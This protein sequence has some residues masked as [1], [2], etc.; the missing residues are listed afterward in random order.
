LR[1]LNRISIFSL[2]LIISGLILCSA[3]NEKVENERS[4]ISMPVNSVSSTSSAIV[5]TLKFKNYQCIDT[6]G[7]GIEAFHLLVPIDW[8]SEG[9]VNWVMDN[10]GMPA[11]SYLRVWKPGQKE[12]FNIYPNQSLFW[13]TNP[14]VAAM[15]PVGSKYFGMEVLEPMKSDQALKKIVIPRFRPA[16]A[17]Y[18]IIK[19]EHL[20]DI[21]GQAGGYVTYGNGVSGTSEA[22][23]IRIE[24]TED[25]TLVEEE[26]YCAVE[27]LIMQM[28]GLQGTVTNIDWYVS[29]IA[30]FKAEKG[31]LDVNARLFQTMVYSLKVDPQW[32][33]KYNQVISYLVQQQIKQIQNAA[34]LSKI[35]SQTNDQIS[36]SI[37]DSYN[38][39]EAVDDKI[40]ESFSQ[41]MRGVDEYSNP[42]NN[43]SVE[44]PSGY[45]NAWTNELGE[46][47]LAD[48]ANY[49]PNI[50]SNLNWQ[51]LEKK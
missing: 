42:V 5:N 37:M 24:Y 36:D 9:K 38:Q 2:L 49:D 3:C 28:Q 18:K 19:E 13:S 14:L 43:S 7:I 32:F 47:I 12:E 22:S 6:Q 48:S 15:F 35:I 45:Q 40:A 21:I 34:Q 50:G 16:I 31:K 17:D 4:G 25:G 26:I 20:D 39:R 27:S 33:N 10:P 11:S 46:Y 8:Q 23:K 51:L 41:Y 29:H 1:I 44:L 30:S